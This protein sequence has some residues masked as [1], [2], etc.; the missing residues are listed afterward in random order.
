M[1]LTS[2]LVILNRILQGYL[3]PIIHRPNLKVLTEAYVN[4]I[5]TR[6]EGDILTATGV[7]FEHGGN[8]YQVHATK[9]VILSAGCVAS[10]S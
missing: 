2:S 6:K 1:H 8:V 7:E 5:V 4:K 10:R 9:E 3:L